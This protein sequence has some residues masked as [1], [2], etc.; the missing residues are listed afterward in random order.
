MNKIDRNGIE[1]VL[2]EHP[3]LL[4]IIE[5]YENIEREILEW[6]SIEL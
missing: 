3:N 6:K 5:N 1:G 2:R 4:E